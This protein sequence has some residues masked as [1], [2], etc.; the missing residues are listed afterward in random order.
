MDDDS[1][2]DDSDYEKDMTYSMTEDIPAVSDGNAD[3]VPQ[4]GKVPSRAASSKAMTPTPPSAEHRA[5]MQLQRADEESQDGGEYDSR[6]F[7]SSPEASPKPPR[8]GQAMAPVVEAGGEHDAADAAAASRLGAAVKVQRTTVGAAEKASQSDS[9]GLSDDDDH[10]D[11]AGASEHAH[12][13]SAAAGPAAVVPAATIARSSAATSRE[14]SRSGMAGFEPQS[15]QP[16]A[17]PPVAATASR[18]VSR[19]SSKAL[20]PPPATPLKRE[21]RDPS[22]Q[23]SRKLTEPSEGLMPVAAQQSR[24][25]VQP[26]SARL[27]QLSDKDLSAPSATRSATILE[28]VARSDVTPPPHESSGLFS[29]DDEGGARGDA[30]IS[31]AVNPA[32]SSNRVGSSRPESARRPTA[33]VLAQGSATAVGAAAATAAVR[34]P[35]AS[36]SEL[37]LDVQEDES[38]TSFAGSTTAVAALTPARP[39]SSSRQPSASRARFQSCS[40]PASAAGPSTSY[41]PAGSSFIPATAAAG[42]TEAVTDDDEVDPL[43]AN[44]VAYDRAPIMS[45][46]EALRIQRDYVRPQSAVPRRRSAGGEVNEPGFPAS[47]NGSNAYSNGTGPRHASSWAASAF[48][49]ALEEGDG[50]SSEGCSTRPQSACTRGYRN[51]AVSTPSGGSQPTPDAAD[52]YLL[53]INPFDWEVRDVCVWLKQQ[54][55]S[56]YRKVFTHKRV[57]GRLLMSLSEQHLRLDLGI[58]QLQH[59]LAILVARDRVRDALRHIISPENVISRTLQHTST[60]RPAS[61]PPARRSRSPSRQ[62][63]QGETAVRD[64]H[65]RLLAKLTRAQARA[66]HIR[67][68]ANQVKGMTQQAE[69]EVGRIRA[70]IRDLERSYA[71]GANTVTDSEGRMPW[72]HTGSGTHAANPH[73]E[74]AGRPYTGAP[75]EETFQPAISPV[76]RRIVDENG[77]GRTGFLGRLENDL[78]RRQSKLKELEKRHYGHELDPR[79]AAQLVKKDY[80]LVQ[81]YALKNAG[82]R[83]SEAAEDYNQELDDYVEGLTGKQ[84]QP[85]KKLAAIRRLQGPAKLHAVAGLVR[86]FMFM[87]RYASDAAQRTQRVETLQKEWWR[88][89]MAG[90]LPE[91]KEAVDLEQADEH[92]A[93]MGWVRS[94][95]DAPDPVTDARLNYLLARAKAYKAEY[96]KLRD[97]DRDKA[98]RGAPIREPQVAMKWE[99]PPWSVDGL[100]ELQKQQADKQR[101]AT[102]ATPPQGGRPTTACRTP[103]G[104]HLD[105]G[106]KLLAGLRPDDLARM[107][108]L[109]GRSKKL[110]V[111]RGIRSRKF[112]EFTEQKMAEKEAEARRIYQELQPQRR[113]VPQEKLDAFYERLQKDSSQREERQKKAAE[114]RALFEEKQLLQSKMRAAS[115]HKSSGRSRPTS[116][117]F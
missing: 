32:D 22:R 103:I 9:L 82:V 23:T 86:G 5:P 44:P 117:R 99:G 90:K 108:K 33:H 51:T 19:E 91:D 36:G 101:A 104:G 88:Q 96:D 4:H 107:E 112:V 16:L 58:D 50:E 84:Q 67:S 49:L 98:P 53:S 60:M 92:F 71:L 100:N 30:D 102:A 12:Q 93:E 79:R 76:S 94:H 31:R 21:S 46:S 7:E 75:A 35:A 3:D 83:L 34:P 66:A 89:A 81:D 15:Q 28:P 37:D 105:H 25:T 97:R 87:D 40:R 6:D 116:A 41:N 95:P 10:A 111:Y 24:V 27:R 1:N 115:P 64:Q 39:G 114:E 54:G 59:R 42:P 14:P 48:P 18:S 78:R 13:P 26:Q 68:Q 113:V 8:S 80:E 56:Q 57:D 45:P 20:N 73:P 43:M 47:S 70:L 74:R 106:V 69:E 61:A 2:K 65:S 85:E 77:G 38:D 62:T 17:P 52:G 72:Q 109:T 55:F 110:A 11:S 63:V 29:S